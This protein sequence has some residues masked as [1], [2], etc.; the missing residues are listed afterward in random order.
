[1]TDAGLRLDVVRSVDGFASLAEEWDRLVRAM[2]RP[3]PFMLHGWL[4][5]WLIHYADEAEPAVHVAWRGDTLVGALPLVRRR[6]LGLVVLAFAGEPHSALADLMLAPGE[7]E[8]TGLRLVDLVAGGSH[9]YSDLFGLPGASRLA[10]LAGP[11][12][13]LVE[14][15]EAPVL[16]L[17]RPWS[18]IYNEKTSSK[19]RNL[20]K[21]RRRQLQEQGSELEVVVARTVDELLPALEDAFRLHELRW[22]G[23]PDGSGFATPAGRRFNRAVVERL[24]PLGAPRIV[25]LKLDGRA[26]AF[27]YYFALEGTMYVYRLAFDPELSRFSPGLVN[28]LD[29][30][31][32]GAE[33]GLSR[34]EFL[35]GDERYKLELAD[36]LEPLYQG[37]GLAPSARGRVAVAS[38]MANIRLRRRLK[39]S[40]LAHKI[41][42]ERLAP[43]RRAVSRVRTLIA[44]A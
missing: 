26:I 32:A 38:R 27:H 5:E 40:E 24:G 22:K 2:P 15:V 19:K 43:V 4:H 39:K 37:L 36:R 17:E 33:E 34:V 25:L 7:D 3:S 21:R 30:I 18:E 9:D 6:R 13:A 42:F 35:G 23:R 11:R 20:H 8:S 44:R 29:A 16:D 14:R 10:G 28:T 12:V 31:E 41:Y 1:M